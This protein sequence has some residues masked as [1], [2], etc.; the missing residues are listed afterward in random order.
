[1]EAGSVRN[2]VRSATPSPSFILSLHDAKTRRDFDR[3]LLGGGGRGRATWQ[4]LHR[5]D[6][7]NRGA[8]DRRALNV[9][10]GIRRGEGGGNVFFRVFVPLVGK[11]FARIRISADLTEVFSAG[12]TVAVHAEEAPVRM[13]SNET[14]VGTHFFCLTEQRALSVPT[15]RESWR[16]GNVVLHPPKI[17]WYQTRTRGNV[18]ER[19]GLRVNSQLHG[20]P[21]LPRAE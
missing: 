5:E 9:D 2:R 20:N 1:M 17:C 11:C 12:V 3:C 8:R 21:S 7:R 14:L 18:K 4:R 10:Y 19:D 16:V 6:S 15:L 13:K